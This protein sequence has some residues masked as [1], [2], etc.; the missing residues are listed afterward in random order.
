MEILPATCFPIPF[1]WHPIP[2]PRGLGEAADAPHWAPG[3]ATGRQ[4][5]EMPLVRMSA[6]SLSLP[7]KPGSTG[8]FWRRREC[9]QKA[10]L[11]YDFARVFNLSFRAGT[12]N[13]Y[14]I[15]YDVRFLINV[16]QLDSWTALC[17]P[18]SHYQGVVFGSLKDMSLIIY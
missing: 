14:S 13:Q 5:T 15:T 10:S 8:A 18:R 12:L 16:S 7:T 4:S 2:N 9:L 11:L 17:T 3:A 6:W 1:C